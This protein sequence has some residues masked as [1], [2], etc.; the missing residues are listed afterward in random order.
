MTLPGL[1]GAARR[2]TWSSASDVVTN[3]SNPA[4]IKG[5]NL[6]P[7][8]DQFTAN[9]PWAGLWEDWRWATWM[10]PQID[11]VATLGVNT[12]RL[13]GSQKALFQGRITQATYWA[14][15]Q[16][17]L[18][19]T[20][21][22][23]LW[24]YPTFGDFHV[25]HWDGT[26][27]V[28]NVTAAARDWAGMLAAAG[29]CIGVNITN[30]AFLNNVY[31][32]FGTQYGLDCLAGMMGEVA[33]VGIPVTQDRVALNAGGWSGNPFPSPIQD[34]CDFHDWHI[35][36]DGL[37][38]ADVATFRAKG[39]FAQGPIVLGEFGG[40]ASMT[41]AAQAARYTDAWTVV[42]GDTT[43]RG[44]IQWGAADQGTT[45][46]QQ[47]GLFTNAWVARTN[48]TTPYAAAAVTR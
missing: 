18:D 27:S 26:V 17:F 24:I 45:T 25:D 38:A 47:W 14:R 32:N 35:Y 4:I 41:S 42:T 9:G 10:Q 5:S 8:P 46:D 2:R 29:N 13:F 36:Y 1:I 20:A 44:G 31:A 7:H 3:L 48:I 15:W 21:G 16:Q 19:Y 34:L 37:S 11:N 40:P 23:G 33:A 39:T 43:V 6:V 30:E 12:I 28:A 22:L